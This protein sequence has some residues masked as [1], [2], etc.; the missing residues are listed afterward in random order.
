LSLQCEGAASGTTCRRRAPSSAR[1]LNIAHL[2]FCASR[3][4]VSVKVNDPL[5]AIAYPNAAAC[6]A[7]GLDDLRRHHPGQT[8]PVGV[9]IELGTA[10]LLVGSG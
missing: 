9:A 6:V 8:E 1:F 7:I 10:R 2:R 4:S 3:R 5:G